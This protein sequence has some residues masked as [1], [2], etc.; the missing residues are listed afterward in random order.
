MITTV[1]Q[2]VSQFW[3]E[4]QDLLNN[5]RNIVSKN[6]PGAIEVMNYGI[7][8]YKLNWNLVHFAAFKNHI[9]FYPTPTWIEHFKQELSQY[10][11]SK[12][13]V[14]FS[15]DKEIPFD[16]IERIVQYRVKENTK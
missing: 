8:T 1:D 13:T 11:T 16:L 12:W 15:L 6:A 2:Y 9:G 3:R 4:N 5:I 10:K 14:Q 7:P